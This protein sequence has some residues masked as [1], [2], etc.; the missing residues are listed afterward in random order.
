MHDPVREGLESMLAGSPDPSLLRHLD[1][2]TECRD[3]V[4]HLQSA[5]SAIRAL[6]PPAD[7][8]PAAG[9]Y[10]RVMDRIDA[11]RSTSIWN[12]FLEPFFAKRLV[13]A[14]AVLTIILS[15]FLFTSPKDDLNA[16]AAPEAI[17]AEQVHPPASEA[18]S[19]QDRDTV[20][21]QLTTYQE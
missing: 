12:V 11:Q 16:G 20:L 4:Q 2:C 21:V 13:A 14:S 1:E 9:F 15:I 8:E 19:E 10:A 6:K 7:L 17:L 18:G 3:A 5:S